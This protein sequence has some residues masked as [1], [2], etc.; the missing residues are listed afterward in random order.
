MNGFILDILG[1]RNLKDCY[2][3]IVPIDMTGLN[4]REGKLT[5]VVITCD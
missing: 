5:R 4:R 2:N 3:Y 1:Q